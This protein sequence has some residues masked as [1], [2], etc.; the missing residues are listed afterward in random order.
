MVALAF[1]LAG[2]AGDKVVPYVTE[3]G[4]VLLW[5]SALLTL[6]TGWDYFKAGLKHVMD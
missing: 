5:I 2:P 4:I 3:M 6:Y 1:L